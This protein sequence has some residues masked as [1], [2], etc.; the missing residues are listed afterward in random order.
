MQRRYTCQEIAKAV[1]DARV[2][3]V[4]SRELTRYKVSFV[5]VKFCFFFFRSSVHTFFIDC[6]FRYD[7]YV[8]IQVIFLFVRWQFF[9]NLRCSFRC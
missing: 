7:S 1:G 2:G 4:A 3:T 9:L 8:A 5:A 6:M